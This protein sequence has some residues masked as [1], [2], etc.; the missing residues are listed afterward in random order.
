M[1]FNLTPLIGLFA[2]TCTSI[3]FAP[4]VFT[5][6]KATNTESISFKMLLIHLSGVTS[7]IV[8]GIRMKDD[9][10]IGFNSL[11]LFLVLLILTRCCFLEWNKKHPHL[12]ETFPLPITSR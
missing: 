3:S 12:K 11:T 4:Q 10:M 6:F 5:I 2:G 9:I 1:K 7:W 8:Y